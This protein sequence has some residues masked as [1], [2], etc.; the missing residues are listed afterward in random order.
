MLE[1]TH[2]NTSTASI[3]VMLGFTFDKHVFFERSFKA[4]T[5]QS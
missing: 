1:E 5:A 2:Y 3:G 4:T